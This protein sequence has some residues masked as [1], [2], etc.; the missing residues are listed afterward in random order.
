MSAYEV[1]LGDSTDVLKDFAADSFDC[2]V[3]SPPY[4]LLRDYDVEGQ[5][6]MESSITDYVAALVVLFAEVH[7]VLTPTGT[8]WLNIGD[9]YAGG[10]FRGGGVDTAT[11]KQKSNRGT[12]V[13]MKTK[14]FIP[15]EVKQKDL[16][17]IPWRVALALQD[18]GWYLRS[19]I[20]WAK[21]NPMPESIR[22]RPTKSHEHI[23]LLTKNKKYYY[24]KITEP[25]GA[26][27]RDVWLI[28]P[29]RKRQKHYASYPIEL[30]RRCIEAGCPEH[31]VVLDPFCGSGTTG[32]VAQDLGRQFVGIDI[33]K[34]Y[35]EMT[36]ERLT[37]VA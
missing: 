8:V 4:Y 33:S 16:M 1:I 13:F 5:I 9:S 12:P 22:D 7:R 29:E 18:Y 34:D 37:P 2:V 28:T 23:F 26:N 24:N 25:S 15:P 31:G 36:K 20:I 14:M 19:D 35:I 27:I 17:G 32:V 3:T 21:P 6:G 10:N 11:A 30:V